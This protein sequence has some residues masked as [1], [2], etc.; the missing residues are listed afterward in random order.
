MVLNKKA[1]IDYPIITWVILVFGLMLL[2]PVFLKIFTSIQTPLSTQLGNITNG[3]AVAQA[4]FNSVMNTTVN[5]WDKVI[6]FAFI[7]AT[8]L[9][10]ISAFFIDTSPFWIILYLFI[11]FMLVLF[12]PDIIGAL[13]NIYN[14]AQFTTEVARLTFIDSLRTNFG[15]ILVG[16][17]VLSG[18][19]IYGKLAFTGGRK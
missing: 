10:L 6:L 1:Q 15:A 19:I 8:L 14:S 2:A 13:D 17:I 16:V 11:S 18:I 12:A 5:F 9:L 7:L 4:N 3:G